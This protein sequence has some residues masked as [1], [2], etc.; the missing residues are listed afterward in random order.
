MPNVFVLSATVGGLPKFVAYG[1]EWPDGHVTLRTGDSELGYADIAHAV[2]VAGGLTA[3][4]SWARVDRRDLP[5]PKFSGPVRLT[6]TELRI[7]R[8]LASGRTRRQIATMLG[9][10]P[11]TVSNNYCRIALKLGTDTPA[12]S[13]LVAVLAGLVDLNEPLDV[14]PIE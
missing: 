14:V 12:A 8:C 9:V 6:A 4:V 11:S 3:Q 13:M 10:H 2:A 5:V 1:V 7:L